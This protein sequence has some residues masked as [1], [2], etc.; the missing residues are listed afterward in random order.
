MPFA[1]S[2]AD[3]LFSI[4]SPFAEAEFS[5]VLKKD[6]LLFS[7]I[8]TEN[9]LWSLKKAI[10]DTPYKN[11]VA[12]YTVPDFSLIEKAEI[13]NKITLS[14]ASLQN[15]FMM[16]PYAYRTSREDRERVLSLSE[17]TTEV[18]FV[19]DVYEKI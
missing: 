14:G 12:D 3:M 2:S 4:F 1:D 6:G 16:T 10:Y 11:E 5:R 19:I 9:H 13:K 18:E 8:P 7:I 15:L 17:V